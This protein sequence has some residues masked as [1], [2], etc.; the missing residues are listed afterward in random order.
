[1]NC[2]VSQLMCAN[3]HGIYD[4]NMVEFTKNHCILWS[5]MNNADQLTN[6]KYSRTSQRATHFEIF[7]IWLF[8]N[9]WIMII[10]KRYI[11]LYV[12]PTWRNLLAKESSYFKYRITYHWKSILSPID[13]IGCYFQWKTRIFFRS[14]KYLISENQIQ[15]YFSNTVL[16]YWLYLVLSYY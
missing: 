14:K 12:Q 7:S 5:S 2:F 13:L 16:F 15:M 6:W 8:N 9:N 11:W 4:K 3:S 10:C 1:M